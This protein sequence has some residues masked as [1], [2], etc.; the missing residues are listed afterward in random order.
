MAP[1][2]WRVRRRVVVPA[3]GGDKVVE[4][5]VF[6]QRRRERGWAGTGGSSLLGGQCVDHLSRFDLVR[7]F[8]AGDEPSLMLFTLSLGPLMSGASIS[9]SA[10]SR[11]MIGPRMWM[12]P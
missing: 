5:Q 6:R 12:T 10:S 1:S 11:L 8:L 7:L 2:S 3:D 4:W 9:G